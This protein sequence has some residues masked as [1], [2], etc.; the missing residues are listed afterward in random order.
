MIS[1]D[2]WPKY[3]TKTEG[4]VGIG[5]LYSAIF[6]HAM[7]FTDCG[8]VVDFGQ[9]LHDA[10]RHYK[11]FHK[12]RFSLSQMISLWVAIFLFVLIIVMCTVSWYQE[13]EARK[14]Y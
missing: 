10:V 11:N 2:Q 6:E 5:T 1:L 3:P 7:D 4:N 12:D 13:R 8:S 14:V 9:L